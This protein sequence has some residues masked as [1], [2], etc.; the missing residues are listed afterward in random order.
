MIAR[1]TSAL[2]ALCF[3]AV[4]SA[5]P[6]GVEELEFEQCNGG[7]VLCCDALESANSLSAPVKGKLETLN[8]DATQLTGQIGVA[9]TGVN[10]FGIGASPS[11][12]NQQ[13]CC[14]N[15]NFN[16]VVALGCIPAN[17]SV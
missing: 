17:A 13:V 8:I 12:S 6:K 5:A 15:N 10:V 7:H 9:C 16:G 1:L 4:A 2:V 11:C 3:F 14:N